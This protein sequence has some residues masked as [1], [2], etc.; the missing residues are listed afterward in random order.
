MKWLSSGNF[1][2]QEDVWSPQLFG[3]H[4]SILVDE[5]CEK[6]AGLRH[7]FGENVAL[8]ER[9]CEVDSGRFNFG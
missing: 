4:V 8:K 6:R 3:T 9:L 1:D 7:A 5:P 2:V